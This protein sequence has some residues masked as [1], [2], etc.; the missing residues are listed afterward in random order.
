VTPG[1]KSVPK[2]TTGGS[3]KDLSMSRGRDLTSLLERKGDYRRRAYSRSLKEELGGEGGLKK[4]LVFGGLG[5]CSR[6]GKE[7]NYLDYRGHASLLRGLVGGGGEVGNL[8]P[9][10]LTPRRRMLEGSQG[11]EGKGT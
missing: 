7:E 3:R 11:K 8:G 10:A 6:G 9:T 5:T 2:N 1:G 4:G